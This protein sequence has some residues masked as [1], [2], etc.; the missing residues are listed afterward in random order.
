MW[1]DVLVAL[2]LVMI[3]EG[4]LPFLNPPRFRR[5]MQMIAQLEDSTLRFGGLTAMILGCLLLYAV[6]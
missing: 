2:A 3:I 1:Q 6:H 5:T 4:M